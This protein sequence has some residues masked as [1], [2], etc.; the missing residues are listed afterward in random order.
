MKQIQVAKIMD[1]S[2]NFYQVVRVWTGEKQFLVKY[3]YFTPLD[4]WK[5]RIVERF[6]NYETALYYICD[7]IK[8]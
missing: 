5:T 3:R 4:G 1:R 6:T 2:R 8:R 7:T